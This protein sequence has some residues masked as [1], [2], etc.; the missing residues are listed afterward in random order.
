MTKSELRQKSL[1]SGS[2]FFTRSNMA[3][4]GDTMANY[5]VRENIIDTYT[6]KDIPVWE[7]Y[8]KQPVK[9]GLQRSAY[10]NKITFEQ[11]H[12]KVDS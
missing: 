9:C 8:R 1:D 2:F 11:T 4:A 10:F 6:Q 12:R 7:L 3:F 5:G